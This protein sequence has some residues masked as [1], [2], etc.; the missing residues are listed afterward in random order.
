MEFPPTSLESRLAHK[1]TVLATGVFD[2]LHLG[3]LRFLQESKKT[4]GS[5][6]K[7]VVVV[8]RDNTVL[9]RKARKPILP[10]AQRREM[11]AALRVVD[12]AILG[13]ERLDLLGVLQEVKPDIVCVGYNQDDIKSAV[14]S[15]IRKE[16][17]PVRVVQIAK[18]GPN[19]FNSSTKLKKRVARNWR[20]PARARAR[21]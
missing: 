17:L 20:R 4:G 6:A 1:R 2:I 16:R 15:L 12:T 18:F 7:L 19:G 11:V 3:H 10:E 14:E 9:R 8:A 13:H 5:G 21:P